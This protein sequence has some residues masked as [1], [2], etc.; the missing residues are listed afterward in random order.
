[1]TQRFRDHSKMLQQ[2]LLL[3]NQ[4]E[5]LVRWL[6]S[7]C[8]TLIQREGGREKGREGGMK[9]EKKEE[10]PNKRKERRGGRKEK[11]SKRRF[12]WNHWNYFN[13]ILLKFTCSGRWK[14]WIITSSYNRPNCNYVQCSFTSGKRNGNENHLSLREQ[15]LQKP[16][17]KL[18]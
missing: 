12:Q 11:V 16:M 7:S 13:W 8:W 4:R 14:S 3:E 10:R 9:E 1:M 6:R 5:M 15:F 18:K 2:Y 17:A